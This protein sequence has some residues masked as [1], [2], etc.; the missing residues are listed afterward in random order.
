LYARTSPLL[1]DLLVVSTTRRQSIHSRHDL[2]G[3]SVRLNSVTFEY[4]AEETHTRYTIFTVSGS[5]YKL[6]SVSTCDRDL[7]RYGVHVDFESDT[8]IRSQRVSEPLRCPTW[9]SYAQQMCVLG[10]KATICSARI[11]QAAQALPLF[12]GEGKN[13]F[14]RW[15]L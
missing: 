13:E 5:A 9:L 8:S 7:N 11:D 15:M 3:G 14:F 10:T 6:R 1:C 12:C 2:P 4:G